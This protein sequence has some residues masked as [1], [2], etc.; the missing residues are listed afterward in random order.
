MFSELPCGSLV[1]DV[2]V[3]FLLWDG[4][5]RVVEHTGVKLSNSQP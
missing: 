3:C 5:L 2:K 1:V 4:Y